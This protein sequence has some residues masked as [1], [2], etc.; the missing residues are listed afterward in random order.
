MK[1]DTLFP[2]EQILIKP[3]FTVA[4]D[5]EVPIAGFY[6]VSP[7]REIRSIM[8]FTDAEAIEFIQI[9][10]NVRSK[11]ASVLGISDVYL[12]QNEDTDHLFHLW[13]FPRYEWMQRFGRKIQSVRPI[14]DYAKKSMT[15]PS[16]LEAV[17]AA[18]AKMRAALK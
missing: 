13:M 6:I 16:D 15:K 1:T 8:D 3:L 5:W 17:R 2:D 10:R 7:N 4:Q 12:F 18:A 14:L 11:M 9:T